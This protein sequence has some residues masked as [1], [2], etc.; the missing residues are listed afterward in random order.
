MG[1]SSFHAAIGAVSAHFDDTFM[2]NRV[3]SAEIRRLSST[4]THSKR[5]IARLVGVSGGKVE[6]TLD[7]AVFRSIS[8]VAGRLE[9]RSV[10]CT[11]EG[12][13]GGFAA[14]AG[15]DAGRAGGLVRGFVDVPRESRSF[16]AGAYPPPDPADRLGAGA[17]G[18]FDDHVIFA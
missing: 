13:V 2:G 17:P 10:R 5:E 11:G 1:V 12:A 15:N 16:A 4:G 3:V 9:L 6:R 18:A 14:D 7:V 8:E